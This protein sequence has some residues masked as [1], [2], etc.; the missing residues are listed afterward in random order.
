MA[1]CIMST[2]AH[3]GAPPVYRPSAEK[4]FIQPPAVFS[5]QPGVQLKPAN[6][7]RVE[8]RP[9]P[10]VYRPQLSG[11][12]ST[13]SKPMHPFQ[14]KAQRQ[15][16]A[17][18]PRPLNLQDRHKPLERAVNIARTGKASHSQS[19]R[20]QPMPAMATLQR[21]TIQ[22]TILEQ[23]GFVK[24]KDLAQDCLEKKTSLGYTPPHINNLVVREDTS[25]HEIANAV[26]GPR[27]VVNKIR[28]G[29]FEAVV[30]EVPTNYVG[31]LIYLPTFGP[32]VAQATNISDTLSF[33]G[34]RED[35]LSF[36]IDRLEVEVTGHDGRH[37]TLSTEVEKHEKVHAADIL[38]LKEKYFVPWDR[39]LTKAKNDGMRFTGATEEEA[40]NEVYK[41][42]GGTPRQVALAFF[43]ET[44]EASRAF[45]KTPQGKTKS[46][47]PEFE[48]LRGVNNYR[49]ITKWQHPV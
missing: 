24:N 13:Q 36:Q 32:W 41:Y 2:K 23:R 28:D 7:F 39:L 8:T 6:T 42:A 11:G 37:E 21:S 22:R 16:T 9:A 4:K 10:P 19:G 18:N 44:E 47:P 17:H 40:V 45:H 3:N 34:V 27:I 46:F 26:K 49:V 48:R 14:A 43:Q 29:E 25:A 31:Y 1:L 35:R 33:V 38:R 15:P 5:V 20:P 30:A 12:S